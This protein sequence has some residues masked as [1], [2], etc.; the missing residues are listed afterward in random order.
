MGILD[1]NNKYDGKFVA[2]DSSHPL[3]DEGSTRS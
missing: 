2:F 1:I 3:V